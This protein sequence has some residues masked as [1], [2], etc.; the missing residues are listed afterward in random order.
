MKQDI[1]LPVIHFNAC[2]VARLSS[3][4]SRRRLSAWQPSCCKHL[5]TCSFPGRSKSSHFCQSKS[6]TLCFFDRALPRHSS[7]HVFVGQRSP[8]TFTG[9]ESLQNAALVRL[10]LRCGGLQSRDDGLNSLLVMLTRYGAEV[11]GAYLVKHILQLILRKSTAFDV[12][13][14]AEILGHTLAVFPSHGCHLLLG[15]L[16]PYALII[17]QIDLG[18]DNEARDAGAMV[19]DLGEPLLANV[20]K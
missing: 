20:F 15:Q 8:A 18:A 1:A 6:S 2:L 9:Y 13:N 12:L 14:S 3:G 19:V 7:V 5:H 10:F 16:F 4:Q 17:A 11:G